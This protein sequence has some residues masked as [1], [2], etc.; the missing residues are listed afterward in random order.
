MKIGMI[1]TFQQP[2][3]PELGWGAEKYIWDL[4]ECL[5]NLGHEI[6]LFGIVGSKR[7]KHGNLVNLNNEDDVIG[8]LKDFRNE[9]D[10]IHD[11]SATKTVHDFC[12]MNNIKSI[13]TNFNTHFLNPTIHKNIVCVS[14]RQKYMGLQ[15]KSGFEGTQWQ[16]SVGYTGYLQSD[17]KVVH[18]G[19]NTDFYYP[20]YDQKE[21]YILHFNSFDYFKGIQITLTI[22]EQLP[23]VKFKIAGSTLW[24][25]HKIV[26]EEVKPIMDSLPNV[27][28][29]INSSNERKRELF[30]KAKAYLFPSMFEQPFAVVCLESLACGTPVITMNY[31]GL[32]EI[33]RHGITGFNANNYDD[34]IFGIQNID[35]INPINCRLDMEKR[36]TRES[37]TKNYINLYEMILRGESW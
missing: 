25:Q 24:E 32:P 13:A 5:N 26:F 27:E 28:Y 30:Q 4:V 9:F 7:P 22:A 3:N 36:F 11:F 12:Q 29:E 23:E 8:Y 17:A 33:V 10:I 20:E 34:L 18:V 2:C 1:T 16:D 19:I 37:M 35:K 21:D 14:Q 15:G 31:G 6:T